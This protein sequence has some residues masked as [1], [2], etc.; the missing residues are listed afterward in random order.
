MFLAIGRPRPVPPRLVVKYGSKTCG[1]SAGAMPDAAVGDGDGDA[2]AAAA[3]LSVTSGCGPTAPTPEGRPRPGLRSGLDAF[4]ACRALTSMLTSAIRSRSASVITSGSA[5]SRSSATAAPG[6]AWAAAADSRQSA[7]MSAGAKSKR[8]GREKS[9][10]S[11]TIRFSR[12]TS[13]SMSATASRS[14]AGSDSAWRS[15]WS[16]ALMIISGLRTS[17]AMT[18]ERRPSDVRRSFC[19]ISRWNRDDRVGQ[20]VERRRQQP[21][22]LVVPPAPLTDR[23]LA[24]Q[25]AGRRHLAH[26]V[27]DVRQRTRN[28]P[29]HREAENR[30][31]QHGDDRGGR[32]PGVNGP[33]AA[34]QLGAR[35]QDQRHRTGSRR[36]VAAPAAQSGRGSTR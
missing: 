2:T 8:I 26:H 1:R 15:V 18:V 28:R 30:R 20:R 19:D 17:C 29:R 5:G 6:D 25:I 10:T 12:A 3:A 7:S 13:S 27:G 24:R 36:Q 31:E 32:E 21:G 35:P 34:K 33:Q 14:A 16:D 4:T 22:V 11:F 9:S 23:D